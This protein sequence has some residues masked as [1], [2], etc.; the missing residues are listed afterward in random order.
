MFWAGAG[1]RFGASLVER[2]SHVWAHRRVSAEVGNR[3]GEVSFEKV[4]NIIRYA[5]GL[6][7]PR[8]RMKEPSRRGC[9]AMGTPLGTAFEGF[10]I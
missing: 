1:R 4:C 2:P 6:S 7:G 5:V 9:D 3:V 10:G 8:G